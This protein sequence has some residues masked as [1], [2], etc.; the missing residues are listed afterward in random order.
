MQYFTTK[1]YQILTMKDKFFIA[2]LILFLF[3]LF[4]NFKLWHDKQKPIEIVKE[5]I[6]NRYIEVKDTL[7]KVIRS[8]KVG[9][10]T[11]AHRC[12]SFSLQSDSSLVFSD[13]ID[14]EKVQKVFSDDST[15]TAYISGYQPNLD[16]IIFRQK[17]IYHSIV[18][19]KTLPYSKSYR[20]NI[21][22][23]GG[24]GFGFA[25]T[26]FEPFIGIGLSFSFPLFS[27]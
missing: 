4:F 25:S 11:V 18:E 9:T 6:V 17:E 2:I 10:L 20:F 8:R 19:I 23:I 5:K 14:I 24:Y 27:Y 1:N 12:D 16:S 22:L 13:S 7:P 15:Y 21:G 3:S 26:K